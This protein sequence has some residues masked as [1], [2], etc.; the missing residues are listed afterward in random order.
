MKLFR[1]TWRML[2][3][4]MPLLVAGACA[5]SSGPEGGNIRVSLTDAPFPYDDVER[6]DV[7]VTRVDAKVAATTEEE[8]ESELEGGDEWVTLATPNRTFNLIELQGGTRATLGSETVT[9]GT[10]QS[11]RLV[12][13]V[14]KSSITLKDG[15]V[16]TGTSDPGIQFPSAGQSGIKVY[17]NEPLNITDAAIDV[18]IDF[19]LARSFVMRGVDMSQGFNFKPVLRATVIGE[20]GTIT[21]TVT[22]DG[23]PFAGATIDI[24]KDGTDIED[25]DDANV[26]ATTSTDADGNYTAAFLLPG[27]YSVR[28]TPPEG[29]SFGKAMVTGITVSSGATTPDVDLTLPAA[30]ASTSRSIR[31]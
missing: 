26:L 18:V 4:V 5:D 9:P 29:A 17:V 27:T 30:S 31:R 19:D 13:D 6:V 10:Y 21:G 7:Y 8:N 23:N 2:A 3:V 11:L 16:L 22:A 1:S 15:T 25:D 28:A 24:L 12:L 14:S 20:T